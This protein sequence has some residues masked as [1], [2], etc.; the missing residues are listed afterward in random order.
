VTAGNAVIAVLGSTRPGNSSGAP[1]RVEFGSYSTAGNATITAQAATVA[2]APGGSI[3]FF[4]GGRAGAATLIANGGATAV[5]GGLISFGSASGSA[6]TGDSARLV[7]NAGAYADFSLNAPFGDTAVGSIEGAGRFS[8]GASLLTVGNLNT[9]TTV[10]GNITDDGGGY[11]GATGGQLTKV[12]TGTLTL[13]GANTYTGL[14]TVAAGAMALN[15]SVAGDALVKFGA[16]LSGSA[17]VAGTLN[18]DGTCI[19]GNSP[20]TYTLGGLNLAS[21]A[22]LEYELGATRDHIVV[23]NNGNVTLGGILNISL[24]DGF[25]PTEPMSLFEGAIGSITGAF[26]AVNA[27]VFNGQI[28]GVVY[29]TNQVTLQVVDAV[30]PP[31]DYNQNGIVDAADYVVWRK[32]LGT[33]YTLDHYNTWRV[34][35]GQTAGSGSGASANAAVPEPS[36]ASL[37]LWAVI[38]ILATSPTCRRDR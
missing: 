15:G 30:L 6:G 1:G 25:I 16:T 13:S 23:T 26:S 24:L 14:T 20:G 27:P 36:S 9:S 3:V 5:N 22:T 31:G 8:L 33:T 17:N 32:G 12:G 34:N 7:V 4:N 11:I 35:F 38:G 2:G 29:G 28:L 37:M 10:S 21:T 18:C 19:I